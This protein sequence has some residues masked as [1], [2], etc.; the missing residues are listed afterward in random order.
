LLELQVIMAVVVQ[1]TL[2]THAQYTAG[3]GL[4][5][6]LQTEE[7]MQGM[8]V[9]LGV[10]VVHQGVITSAAVEAEVLGDI[11]VMGATEVHID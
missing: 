3:E 2:S 7:D 10:K 4:Q 5:V 11:L 6:E 9:V 1:A 8:V